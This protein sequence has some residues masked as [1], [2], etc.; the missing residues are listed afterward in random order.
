MKIQI[1]PDIIWQSLDPVKVSFACS[2]TYN[3]AGIAFALQSIEERKY[4]D[5]QRVSVLLI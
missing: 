4:L 1:T 3:D 2:L 5:T